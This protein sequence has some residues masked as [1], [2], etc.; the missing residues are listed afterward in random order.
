[1]VVRTQKRKHTKKA[2]GKLWMMKQHL[3]LFLLLLLSGDEYQ[4]L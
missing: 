3:K 1:M 4:L 2:P